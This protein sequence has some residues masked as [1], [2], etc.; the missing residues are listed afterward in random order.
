VR[1][2]LGEELSAECGEGQMRDFAGLCCTYSEADSAD[3]SSSQDPESLEIQ[4]G[5]T[6]KR[7][8]K[9]G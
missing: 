5:L 7:I 6:F 9:L 2:T 4:E 3:L 8:G 1:A